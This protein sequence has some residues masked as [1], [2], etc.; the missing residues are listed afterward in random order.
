MNNH[1]RENLTFLLN[2]TPEVLS[3]WYSKMDEDSITY[4]SELLT[5]YGKEMALKQRFYDVEDI[6]IDG[7]TSDAELYLMKFRLKK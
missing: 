4:A 5:R 2:A 3:D 6:N 7:L 1:D